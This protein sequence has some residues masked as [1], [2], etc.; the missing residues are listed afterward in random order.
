MRADF[1]VLSTKKCSTAKGLPVLSKKNTVLRKLTTFFEIC[2][3]TFWTVQQSLTAFN[4]ISH[5]QD[6][7]TVGSRH[8]GQVYCLVRFFPGGPSKIFQ[9]SMLTVEKIPVFLTVGGSSTWIGC[10]ESLASPEI[11]SPNYISTR[12]R[13][14]DVR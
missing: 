5:G 8:G 12:Y 11:A 13:K 3:A 14:M 1:A 2:T 7:D 9:C 4:L 6:S 10:P